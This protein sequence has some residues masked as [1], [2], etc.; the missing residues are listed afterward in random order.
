MSIHAK[1]ALTTAT[2][3]AVI[4]YVAQGQS[5][6]TSLVAVLMGQQKVE[7]LGAHTLVR[8]ILMD[9]EKFELK[10]KK[11]YHGDG[12]LYEI[13]LYCEPNSGHGWKPIA[14]FYHEFTDA[15]KN[16]ERIV[17]LWNDSLLPQAEPERKPPYTNCQRSLMKKY[18]CFDCV[19]YPDCDALNKEAIFRVE[20]SPDLVE[21][22][23]RWLY[24]WEDFE[25]N[26]PPF[27]LED[28][29]MGAKELISLIRPS[30]EQEAFQAGVKHGTDTAFAVCLASPENAVMKF[31][32]EHIQ[33]A[34][35]Q[36]MDF[37]C[38]EC[39]TPG[40]T[41]L[42]IPQSKLKEWNL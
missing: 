27:A 19:L 8:M 11:N 29:D 5:N 18:Q 30:I 21:Q 16:A 41:H 22:V 36:L 32:D 28:W 9:K 10:L 3:F 33:E 17:E 37:K 13:L 25:F 40:F 20:P 38:D 31:V 42:I 24:N 34:R 35:K 4:I 12:R 6:L 39:S 1:I 26:R 2:D 7:S 23:A 14:K 15:E